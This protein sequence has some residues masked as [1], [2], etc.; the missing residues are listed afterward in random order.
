MNRLIGVHVMQRDEMIAGIFDTAICQTSDRVGFTVMDMSGLG[1]DDDLRDE[2][3]RGNTRQ[4]K[5]GSANLAFNRVSKPS[6]RDVK[7]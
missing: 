1:R 6:M 3:N 2:S 5:D 7:A 4:T